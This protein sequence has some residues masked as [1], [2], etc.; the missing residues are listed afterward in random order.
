MKDSRSARPAAR[1]RSKAASDGG[2]A[3]CAGVLQ[4]G[5]PQEK[6]GDPA[7][8]Y[9]GSGAPVSLNR[10]W[11]HRPDATGLR[12]ARNRMPR[13]ASLPPPGRDPLLGHRKLVSETKSGRRRDRMGRPLRRGTALRPRTGRAVTYAVLLSGPQRLPIASLSSRRVHSTEAILRT[14]SARISGEVA[15]FIRTNP[16]PPGPKAIPELRAIRPRCRKTAAGS[17]PRASFRQS[18]QAR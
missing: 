7:R 4:G 12:D 13:P 5:H 8:R 10:G 11:T 18:S 6:L 2:S 1:I 15:R 16:A 9:P 14:P 3:A 17:L